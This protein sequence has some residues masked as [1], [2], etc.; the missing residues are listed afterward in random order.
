MPGKLFKTVAAQ[1]GTTKE[2]YVPCT[3]EYDGALIYY[4]CYPIASL[5]TSINYALTS[6]RVPHDFNSII[7]ASI[8]V[9]PK[10]TEASAN[11]DIYS[12]YAQ[13]GEDYQTHSESNTVSTYNVTNNQIF[14]VNIAGILTSLA[15]NDM[16]GIK[17]LLSN[18]THDVNVLGVR[19]KYS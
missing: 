10:S 4:G 8:V 7:V 2:F 1:G 5:G 13:T 3:Y 17:L 14:E 16:V 11:W 18:S 12:N 6:F 9:I 19:F 15:A